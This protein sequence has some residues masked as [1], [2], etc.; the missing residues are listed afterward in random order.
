MERVNEQLHLPMLHHAQVTGTSHI[1]DPVGSHSPRTA[2]LGPLTARSA[3][4]AS[5]GL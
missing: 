3:V 2:L 5:P 1:K 4:S